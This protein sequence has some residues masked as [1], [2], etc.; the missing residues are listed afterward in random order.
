M[1]HDQRE[2]QLRFEWGPRG[3]EELSPVSD[4]VVIVDVLTFSTAVVV[5]AARGA[6]V[7][8]C[9]WRDDSAADYARSVEAFLASPRGRSR[10]S[11]SP[12]SLMALENGSRIVLPSPNGA[13]LSLKTGATATFA[14][15]LRNARAV[16]AAARKCGP[17]VAVIAGGEQWP[18]GD[19]RPALEDHI[20][21]GAILSHLD[22]SPSPE[23]LA[24]IAVFESARSHL[25]DA[26]RNCTSGK[27]LI[28]WGFEDDVALA[29]R[30]NS[31]DVAPR[32]REGAFSGCP[33]PC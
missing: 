21:A 13:T 9:R 23:A 30:L 12:R 4:A 14:G 27:E 15:C 22:G 16:A 31:D 26:L 17:L 1:T 18:N 5:A 25:P 6:A 29:A 28:A 11:L 32:L 3:V 2:S 24:A 20:G 33:S 8:P 10:Y 7:F 19:L